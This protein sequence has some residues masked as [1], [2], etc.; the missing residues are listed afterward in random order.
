MKLAIYIADKFDGPVTA[1]EAASQISE[2]NAADLH[3]LWSDG[4]SYSSRRFNLRSRHDD[5]TLDTET[6][7]QMLI[8]HPVLSSRPGL[9]SHLQAKMLHLLGIPSS[10]VEILREE[11]QHHRYLIIA[12]SSL[13]F[14][15]PSTFTINHTFHFRLHC[16][17]RSIIRKASQNLLSVT[18]LINERLQHDFTL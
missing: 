16:N 2:R 1:S 8:A 18:E 15:E 10:A 11:L 14:E 13:L 4:T 6:I 17:Y 7:V 12:S 3:L 9:T 5:S